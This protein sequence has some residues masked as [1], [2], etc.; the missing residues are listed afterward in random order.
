MTGGEDNKNAKKE[1]TLLAWDTTQWKDL[2]SGQE[3]YQEPVVLTGGPAFDLTALAFSPDGGTLAT[4][5]ENGEILTWNFNSQSING[6]PIKEHS[7]E[8]LGLDFGQFGDSLLLVSSGLD[9]SIVM[10]NLIQLNNLHAPLT[11]D[12]GNPVRLAAG[13]QDALTIAGTADGKLTLWDVNTASGEETSQDTGKEILD[14][15]FYLSPDGSR[16]AYIPQ[17]ITVLVQNIQPDIQSGEA[18]SIT[19]PQVAIQTKNAAG[20]ITENEELATIDSLAIS[21]D[22]STL[23]GGMCTVREISTGDDGNTVDVCTQNEIVLWEISTGK[24]L[25]QIPTD[26]SSPILSLAFNPVI[27]D[28]ISIAAGFQDGT[29]RLVDQGNVSEFPLLGLGGPVISLAYHQDGDILAAGSSNNLIALWNL[30]PPQLIGDPISGADGAV[31]G[32]A[33]SPNTSILYRGTDKGT[34]TRLD[35]ESWKQLDCDLVKRNMT[36]S[37]WEQFFPQDEYAATCKDFP[38]ET[39]APMSTATLAGAAAPSTPTP[40]GASAPTP[41]P[42]PTPTP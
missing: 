30:R 19:V 16:L 1:K 24:L 34:V 22:G 25:Q 15:K 14:G 29:I 6:P 28:A 32:L 5:Y 20:E 38:L 11:K 27:T 7:R 36:R 18:I 23:A 41:T 17:A 42:T 26:Q 21:Q 35:I 33:F 13:Q 10:N 8:V 40:P 9:R 31:T 4:A 37:E 12:K 39:P 2:E 3:T